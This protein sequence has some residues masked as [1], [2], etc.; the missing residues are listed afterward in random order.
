MLWT[1][2]LNPPLFVLLHKGVICHHVLFMWHDLHACN[3]NVFLIKCSQFIIYNFWIKSKD[4][5]WTQSTIIVCSTNLSTQ[6]NHYYQACACLWAAEPGVHHAQ[7]GQLMSAQLALTWHN[8][9]NGQ[10]SHIAMLIW[11]NCRWP[12]YLIE[13]T[14]TSMHTYVRTYTTNIYSR[15][16]YVWDSH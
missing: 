3:F 13:L 6:R 16:I 12:V 7:C 5:K 1:A 9:C 2:C 8:A 4:V 11:C 15:S 14:Y 10:P